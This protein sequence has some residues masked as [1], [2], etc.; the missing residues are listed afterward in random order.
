MST[1]GTWRNS[2]GARVDFT[3]AQNLWAAAAREVL[4]EVATRY[5]AYITYAELGEAV[6]G[7][8]GVQTRSLLTNWIGGVLGLV[9]EEC[10]RRREPV[11]TALCVRQDETVGPGYVKAVEAVYGFVPDDPDEHAAQERLACYRAF[12]AD[13]P[14]GGGEP[15]LTRR[16]RFVRE[17]RTRSLRAEQPS[18]TCPTC[19]MQLPVSGRC[20]TCD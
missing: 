10:G 12:A 11:L 6:Q 18:P 20:D 14:P 7:R 13:L 1:P 8:T 17:E 16:V 2:D 19:N 3:A 4:L 15:A 5:H 9:A